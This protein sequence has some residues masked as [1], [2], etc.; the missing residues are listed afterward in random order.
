MGETGPIRRIIEVIPEGEPVLPAPAPEPAPA[1]APAPA[2]E[3][4]AP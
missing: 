4:P 1:P 3:T 2:P